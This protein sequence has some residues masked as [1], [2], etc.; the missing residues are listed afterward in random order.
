[1]DKSRFSSVKRS[2]AVNSLMSFVFL[3]AFYV[4]FIL[5]LDMNLFKSEAINN[6][7]NQ[8]LVLPQKNLIL[9]LLKF[10]RNYQKTNIHE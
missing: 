5:F 1:M 3:R 9:K 6:N 2:T 7:N 4:V 10:V 8:F